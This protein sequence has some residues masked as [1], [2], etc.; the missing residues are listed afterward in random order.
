MEIFKTLAY[1]DD[2]LALASPIQIDTILHRGE[3]WL[4]PS[5]I[6]P[7]TGGWRMPEIAIRLR[8]LSYEEV[9]GRPYR[10]RLHRPIPKSV[11]D[12]QKQAGYEVER[13]L[14]PSRSP[15]SEPSKP[16]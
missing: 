13:N 16:H 15:A 8:G 6:A 5:W 3:W 11:L 9:E 14:A 4:V 1:L 10:F 2:D 7:H 12:G